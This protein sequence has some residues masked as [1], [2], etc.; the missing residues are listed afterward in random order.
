MH[1][2]VLESGWCL[3]CEKTDFYPCKI[4]FVKSFLQKSNIVILMSIYKK[5]WVQFLMLLDTPSTVAHGIFVRYFQ[6]QT[7][8]LF[9]QKG[10]NVG[11]FQNQ[12]QVLFYQKGFK[13]SKTGCLV[14]ALLT[15]SMAIRIVLHSAKVVHFTH[16][17]CFALMPAR[18]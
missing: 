3:F 14:Q 1:N 4:N 2:G 16:T 12:T 7:Q 15:V 8:V 10:F 5:R 11:H 9:Y 6:N 17:T 18:S 13:S